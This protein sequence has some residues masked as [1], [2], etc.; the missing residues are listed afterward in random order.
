[1]E[2]FELPVT[3]NGK[4]LMLPSALQPWG[5]TYRIR[6]E[7]D[8]AVV[9]FEKDEERNWR[10]LVEEDLHQKIDAELLQNIVDALDAISS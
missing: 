8:Q 9:F 10:A 5:Y 7:I 4:E 2:Y 1:M 6:V 3:Y